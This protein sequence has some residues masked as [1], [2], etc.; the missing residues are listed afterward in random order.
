[1]EPLRQGVNWSA[2]AAHSD[3]IINPEYLSCGMLYSS[4]K[5]MPGLSPPWGPVSSHHDRSFRLWGN[6]QCRSQNKKLMDK[7]FHSHLDA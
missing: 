1:M 4:A 7:K 6:H 2:I 3:M 5:G